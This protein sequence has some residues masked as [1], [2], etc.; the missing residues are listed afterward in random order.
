MY[1]VDFKKIRRT[2]QLTH[3]NFIWTFYYLIIFA[4]FN[5]I[6][7]QNIIQIANKDEPL[8]NEPKISETFRSDSSISKQLFNLSL[9]LNNKTKL[10]EISGK[11]LLNF[12]RNVKF[13]ETESNINC[14]NQH[15]LRIVKRTSIHI[16]I[17]HSANHKS[18][19]LYL[20]YQNQND[21]I[22]RYLGEVDLVLLQR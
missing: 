15:Q 17:Q 14:I 19:Q 1:V 21:I 20:C 2:S 12:D 9:K 7:G 18:N 16:L 13:F 10:I 3:K 6:H 4:V 8:S 22:P 5:K 11:N